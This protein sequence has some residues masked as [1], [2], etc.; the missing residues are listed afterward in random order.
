MSDNTV[1]YASSV[2]EWV[3]AQSLSR[4]RLFVTPWTVAHHGPPSM[5]FSRQAPGV[6]IASSRGSTP[7]RDWTWGSRISRLKLYRLSPQVVLGIQISF[8]LISFNFIKLIRNI[9]FW[10]I[11]SNRISCIILLHIS[12]RQ[13]ETRKSKMKR[14]WDTKEKEK[15]EKLKKD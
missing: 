13:S 9:G 10:K 2:Y 5:E 8:F 15:R 3:S 4:V 6:P 7:P 14:L 1:S 12:L 11:F